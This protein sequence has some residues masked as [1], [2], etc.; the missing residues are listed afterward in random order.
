MPACREGRRGAVPPAGGSVLAGQDGERDLAWAVAR[1]EED[2]TEGEA[3]T[4][5][6]WDVIEATSDWVTH[7]TCSYARYHYRSRSRGNSGVKGGYIHY[8]YDEVD[9][10]NYNAARDHRNQKPGGYI[11]RH[12]TESGCYDCKST[13]SGSSGGGLCFLTKA[14]VQQRGE[15]DDGPTLTEMRTFR[16]GWM[17]DYPEGPGLIKEYYETAPAIMAAIPEGHPEWRWIAEQV[18]D[19]LEAIRQGRHQ[20]GMNIS[21]AMV[22]RLAETWLP[23][24][25]HV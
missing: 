18:D 14:V 8:S 25:V 22:E 4:S 15:A 1:I 3:G 9:Y 13:Y 23:E 7:N 2:R 20:D 5:Y 19:S 16:D 24:T 17:M 11:G 12:E 21:R 6:S 10:S